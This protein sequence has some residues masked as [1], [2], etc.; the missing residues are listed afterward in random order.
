MKDLCAS[1]DS[2]Q[3]IVSFI[4]NATLGGTPVWTDIDT[5]NSVIEYDTNATT[6]TG[7]TVLF[8]FGLGNA[9]GIN[10]KFEILD[11]QIEPGDTLTAAVRIPSGG[12]TRVS[13]GLNW[14]EDQ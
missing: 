3:C 9:T 12:T 13:V 10:Q 5:T 2:R 1:T 6:V 14:F 11:L 7:G 8:S 4:R